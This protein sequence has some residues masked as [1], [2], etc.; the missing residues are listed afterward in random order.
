[1]WLLV[2]AQRGNVIAQNRVARVLAAGRGL[3]PDP[4]EAAKW[5]V[6]AAKGGRTDAWL[7][8]FV[9]RLS[10]KDRAEAGKRAENWTTLHAAEGEIAAQK[11]AKSGG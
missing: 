6:L 7:D 9:G 4:I 3:K 8:E 1:Q 10:E 2:A 5:H 11:A